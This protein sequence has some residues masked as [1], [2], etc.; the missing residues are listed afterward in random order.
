MHKTTL[1]LPV[2]DVRKLRRLSSGTPRRGLTYHI[3]RAVREYVTQRGRA[4]EG[5][6]SAWRKCKGMSRRSA[7]GDAVA[8]QRTLRSEWDE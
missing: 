5:H 4:H 1:Y 3:Q 2:S 7:F 8:Y 6:L